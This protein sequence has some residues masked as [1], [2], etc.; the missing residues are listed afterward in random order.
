MSFNWFIATF[1]YYGLTLGLKY[2]DADLY[3]IGIVQAVAEIIGTMSS[4][5]Q[6]NCLGRKKG[7]IY[8]GFVAGIACIMYQVIV[9][10]GGS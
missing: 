6:A 4:G 2:L 7:L 8:N 9:N 10:I 3:V 1:V 5:W